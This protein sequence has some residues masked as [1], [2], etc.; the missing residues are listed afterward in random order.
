MNDTAEFDPSEVIGKLLADPLLADVP[1]SPSVDDVE[2]LIAVE[3]GLAIAVNIQRYD[4]EVITV[5]IAQNSTVME[6]KHAFQRTVSVREERL[7]GSR[8]ISWRHFW[9]V[10]CFM[11]NGQRLLDNSARLIDLGLYNNAT[12]TFGY[13][14]L[15]RREARIRTQIA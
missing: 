9:R 13:H 10:E 8:R 1:A 15:R 5:I 12:L 7:M 6:L 14:K 3:K 2:R 4:G 11:L